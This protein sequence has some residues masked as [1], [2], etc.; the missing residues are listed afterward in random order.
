MPVPAT[1]LVA[2]AIVA[3]E[4][5]VEAITIVARDELTP[6][7]RGMLIAFLSLKWVFAL[8]VLKLRPGPALG[9]VLAEGTTVVAAAGA[10]DAHPLARVAL[11]T[12]AVTAIVLLARSLHAFPTVELPRP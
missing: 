11:A 2:A 7:L 6:G 1:L 8:R 4:A 12:T 5:L 9:L 3:V 10:T